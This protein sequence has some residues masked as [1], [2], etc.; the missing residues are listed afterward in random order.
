MF[1]KKISHSNVVCPGQF[2]ILGRE[3][4]A[5]IQSRR[6]TVRYF[7]KGARFNDAHNT[8][9]SEQIGADNNPKTPNPAQ[10]IHIGSFGAR[11]YNVSNGQSLPMQKIENVVSNSA[12][13]VLCAAVDGV[14]NFYAGFAQADRSSVLQIVNPGFADARVRP[15]AQ[16]PTGVS[17]D[18]LPDISI[19]AKSE[20]FV[21]VASFLPPAAHGGWG[22]QLQ[23]FGSKVAAFVHEAVQSGTQII[24]A[25]VFSAGGRA[26]TQ[27]TFTDTFVFARQE[28]SQAF[29]DP[30]DGT[31]IRILKKEPRKE[32]A[33]QELGQEKGKNQAG[34][35]NAEPHHHKQ[36]DGSDKHSSHEHTDT[37]GSADGSDKA[38]SGHEHATVTL[39]KMDGKVARIFVFE[40]A[41]LQMADFPL[42]GVPPG[43]YTVELKTPTPVY[44]SVG[45]RGYEQNQF[46]YGWMLDQPTRLFRRLN[47]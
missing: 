5:S 26:A 39:R 24:G 37:P 31:T 2:A 18:N 35:E 30:A 14:L 44:A 13:E 47:P 36:A 27:H 28:D 33:G 17:V 10:F 40:I 6:G 3:K 4:D 12:I 32:E 42:G 15:V 8:G 25:S 20:V 16:T 21:P 34:S 1:Q 22:L 19:P 46:L 38:H 45:F 23:A 29:T 9:K 43:R 7:E 11:V 41:G